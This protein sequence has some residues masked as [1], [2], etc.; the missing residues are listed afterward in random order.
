MRA[1]QEIGCHYSSIVRM[2][3]GE[4]TP[5]HRLFERITEVALRIL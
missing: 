2:Q 5:R 3:R 1:A 4:F